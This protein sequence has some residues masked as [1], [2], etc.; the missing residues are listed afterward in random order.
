MSMS[1]YQEE[2]DA[3]AASGNLRRLPKIDHLDKWIVSDGERM[4]NLSSND[5]LGLAERSDW[6]AEFLETDEGRQSLLSSSS[7]RLLT[8][9]FPEYELLEQTIAR[10]FGREAVLLFNSGYHANTG[11]LPALAGKRD[12][13]L[14]DKLVHASIID[15][16]KL[17]EATF[18]RFRHNDY[19]QLERLLA[20]EREHYETI[21]VVTESLFSMDG[22]LADLDRL[23]ALK[24]CY[25]N[26]MLYVDEAHAIGVRGERGLGLAEE[27]GHLADIDLLVGTFGKALAS[28]GAYLVCS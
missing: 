10:S 26:V 12:L 22:D 28:M 7:S 14:A 6:K 1:R 2:L 3:L 4:L 16:L 27:T 23:V 19:D 25:P 5:Y 20:V 13:I 18:K 8:G 21:F 24:R 17:G 15:G 11:I 9:N